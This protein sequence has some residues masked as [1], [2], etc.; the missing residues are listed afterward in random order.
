MEVPR[1]TPLRSGPES[2]VNAPIRPHATACASRPL[3]PKEQRV[4]RA[5]LA[6]NAPDAANLAGMLR[7]K[8]DATD[9]ADARSQIVE[10][11]QQAL[12]DRDANL[13]ALPDAL[14]ALTLNAARTTA[15]RFCWSTFSAAQPELAALIAQAHV[16]RELDSGNWSSMLMALPS[17]LPL[18][19]S[20]HGHPQV[21]ALLQAL[22]E[23][24]RSG[25]VSVQDWVEQTDRA[26]LPDLGIRG[27]GP[28]LAVAVPLWLFSCYL[29][30]P[31]ARLQGAGKLMANL[32]ACWQALTGL[33]GMGKAL[34]GGAAHPTATDVAWPLLPD[35]TAAHSRP[36]GTGAAMVGDSTHAVADG[37]RTPQ[38]LAGALTDVGRSD[39]SAGQQVLFPGAAMA[40]GLLPMPPMQGH[41]PLNVLAPLID[42]IPARS[43]WEAFDWQVE[44]TPGSLFAAIEHAFRNAG[45]ALEQR[46][47]A[48]DALVAFLSSP[49][50]AAFVDAIQRFPAVPSGAR[51]SIG[52][53]G[54][55]TRVYVFARMLERL[56]RRMRIPASGDER[57]A[58]HVLAAVGRQTAAYLQQLQPIP[59]DALQAHFTRLME[60]SAAIPGTPAASYTE[61]TLKAIQRRVRAA[62]G[63]PL[64]GK[65]DSRTLRAWL[66]DNRHPLLDVA[67]FQNLTAAD[68]LLLNVA[69][70]LR[71]LL[72]AE[73]FGVDWDWRTLAPTAQDW[74]ARFDP[75]ANADHAS[76]EGALG[77]LYHQI[78]ATLARYL[79]L[80]P[81]AGAP[82]NAAINDLR[83]MVRRLVEPILQLYSDL[84]LPLERAD[85]HYADAY[86]AWM[87]FFDLAGATWSSPLLAVMESFD[88]AGNSPRLRALL[89]QDTGALPLPSAVLHYLL[90][91]LALPADADMQDRDR[92]SLYRGQPAR[93]LISQLL[94]ADVEQIEP[95]VAHAFFRRLAGMPEAAALGAWRGVLLGGS[96][97]TLSPE[98]WL[99]LQPEPALAAFWNPPGAGDNREGLVTV[100]HAALQ[101]AVSANQTLGIPALW[102]HV[103]N[104]PAVL[105]A[106]LDSQAGRQAC[107]HHL[108]R[109][110]PGGL[111]TSRL[112]PHAPLTPATCAALL[113][114]S[115]EAQLS[116]TTAETPA[117]YS[118]DT[119]GAPV[120]SL[121]IDLSRQHPELSAAEALAFA[122]GLLGPTA[123]PAAALPA[124]PLPFPLLASPAV[125][126]GPDPLLLPSLDTLLDGVGLSLLQPGYPTTDTPPLS[127][128]ER[129]DLMSR[130]RQFIGVCQPLLAQAGWL[131]A[132]ADVAVSPRGAQELLARRMLER[133]IGLARIDALRTQ[134]QSPDIVNT[135]YV[136]LAAELRAVIVQQNPD[137]STAA[138]DLLYWL[139][140]SE[141]EQPVLLVRGIP[142]WLYVGR[143][144]QSVALLH[145]ATLLEGM[146]PGACN[147]ATFEQ[148]SALSAQLAMPP[149]TAGEHDALHAAW[150]Q[151]LVPAALYYALAHGAV[152]GVTRIDFFSAAQAATA[153]E[154]LQQQ[155]RAHA[156][157]VAQLGTAPPTRLEIGSRIL[158]DAGVDRAL[159]NERPAD[160]EPG[161]LDA[162]G[163]V[164]ARWL[165]VEQARLEQGGTGLIAFDQERH[166]LRASTNGDTLL[167]LVVADAYVAVNGPT[168]AARFDTAFDTYQR[169]VETGLA[170]IIATLLGELPDADRQLLAT[171]VCTPQR[172]A[173][174]ERKGDQGLLLRCV[175]L[176]PGGTAVDIE[177]FPMAGV[178]RRVW[179]HP[180]FGA[181]V[182]V[183]GFMTG[184]V[185]RT[186]GIEQLG[187]LAHLTLSPCAVAVSGDAP[188]AL[189][190]LAQA[191][192]RHLWQPLLARAR[193]DALDQHTPLE[194]VWRAERHLLNQIA[195][196]LA[197]GYK[198]IESLQA[199]DHST[200][201]IA[202]CTLDALSLW[203]PGSE[204]FSSTVRILGTAGER[205]IQSIASEAGGALLQLAKGY[206]E[207]SSVFVLGKGARWIAGHALDSALHGAG[208]LRGVLRSGTVLDGAMDLER[209]VAA[210]H[211][212]AAAFQAHAA[213]EP[214]LAVVQLADG[215][216]QLASAVGP[217]WYRWDT[218]AK[219]PYG[220]PLTH[221]VLTG[222]HLP[223]IIPVETT[224]DGLRINLGD[225][226][227]VEI[228][229]RSPTQWGVWI[230][231][232]PYRLDAADPWLRAQPH[233]PLP[234]EPGILQ[235]VGTC[236]PKR[237]LEPISCAQGV[238]LQFVPYQQ[239]ALPASPD[240]TGLG[241]QVLPRREYALAT[242]TVEAADGTRTEVQAM[243]HEG[244]VQKW[245]VPTTRRGTGVGRL[246][247]LT[248]EELAA[249]NLPP[250][251]VYPQQLRGTVSTDHAL[252]LPPAVDAATGDALH[253]Q[254][255][256]IDIG[257][258][259]PGL[260]DGRRLRGVV[261]SPAGT[262]PRY[263]YVEPDPGVVYRAVLRTELQDGTELTFN[264]LSATPGAPLMGDEY[265]QALDHL[266]ASDGNAGSPE[267]GD[268]FMVAIDEGDPPLP[269]VNVQG[270]D[271]SDINAYLREVEKYRM[272]RLRGSM[273]Q[274]RENIA[275]IAFG[276]LQSQFTG[277]QLQQYPSYDAYRDACVAQGRP[278]V[279]IGY[280]D[281]VLYGASSQRTFVR[282]ARELIPDWSPLASGS[283]E[284]R[285]SLANILNALFPT[286]G[287]EATWT[288]LDA[289]TVATEQ[290]SRQIL[291][292]THGANLAV[293]EVTLAD[294]QRRVYYALSGGKK[295]A[296]VK[297][298]AVSQLGGTPLVDAR[299]AVAGM[300]DETTYTS[301]PVLRA[302]AAEREIVFDR[303]KDSEVAIVRTIGGDPDVDET[304]VV[305]FKLHSVLDM[306][307]SCAGVTL[308]Q[309]FD[310]MGKTATP[311]SVRYLR[312]YRVSPVVARAPSS[313]ALNPPVPE[314]DPALVSFYQ[315][316]QKD[317][318]VI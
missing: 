316:W 218:V 102:T 178:A 153:L 121:A 95:E 310:R 81:A 25:L 71:R 20:L 132:S 15:G 64:P 23:T 275:R 100:I 8:L 317:R 9:D 36:N 297:L 39:P 58:L 116:L 115:T 274:D 305:S 266:P 148:V 77:A 40:Q 175:P 261:I 284:E 231:G 24:V 235:E 252:G 124:A 157:H 255:P 37:V 35:A 186:R 309:A 18:L 303:G 117:T 290:G 224:E 151:A 83:V 143:S 315:R 169:T 192:A 85:P 277:E 79:E 17:L 12:D 313:V 196:F 27:V 166:A 19:P 267:R 287:K 262:V 228:L 222:D 265:M 177:L 111:P 54:F 136:A 238:R 142:D 118:M 272:L 216:P 227:N 162:H 270:S 292:Q 229:Q 70:T 264:R 84:D 21:A 234:D 314:P 147:L 172:I 193:Q 26:L 176:A 241:A 285:Q 269:D 146:Q 98:E 211:S 51:R 306:C 75:R 180:V 250:T 247:P 189:K 114:A 14:T 31:S 197:P 158:T 276:H 7:R 208:W 199:G 65:V 251:V 62:Y 259:V 78:A 43:W 57:H 273:E 101:D 91:D 126:P 99:T 73:R 165:R 179:L 119:D 145:G 232:K 44:H 6:I 134:L 212:D 110:S 164:P 226:A 291:D 209:A 87:T 240:L 13:A 163:M 1:Q 10:R 280:A 93:H 311:F 182:D 38:A 22:P 296:N 299:A 257:E 47:P 97:W 41:L 139:L 301:L 3:N 128:P 286:V 206:A 33:G 214:S 242:H 195:E 254:M 207:Q 4:L 248:A 159:W 80:H 127:P 28:A 125:P 312:E 156:L 112:D 48:P 74:R 256:V 271:R 30:A 279:L 59:F 202:G 122:L 152:T 16:A 34:F 173:L 53:G 46:P 88:L 233:E 133:Y 69:V 150:A 260:G 61:D 107:R 184:R 243:V 249:L 96:H 92:V 278:N 187:E 213:H 170:G 42:R 281:S 304:Q 217:E 318:H 72:D 140:A 191:A 263:V 205:T 219:R 289:D 130:T 89:P 302:D 129:W 154:F 94:D 45:I 86:E 190:Q 109:V 253:S 67:T 66:V 245:E 90:G 220:P 246:V 200:L 174:G 282:L 307:P 68:A 244:K 225:T 56:T 168:T 236:R 188:D 203:V 171:A 49:A 288:A 268:G 2:V 11:F 155:Q 201:T 215:T 298:Q 113:A 237:A 29:P 167:D 221:H 185:S 106:W 120:L 239:N 137:A 198:C 204:F 160:I 63:V 258:L 223:R 300:P 131:D 52:S 144:L 210:G 183:E 55:E 293:A 308:T 194:Q 161:Y 50:A 5:L 230:H 135:T 295:A 123:L 294:G 82:I 141:L 103:I 149:H 105:G 138:V 32:P 104:G 108:A 60:R 76:W 283:R 181:M